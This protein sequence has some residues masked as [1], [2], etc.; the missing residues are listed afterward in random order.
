MDSYF[1]LVVK[2]LT[3]EELD[4]FSSECFDFG[5]A[6]VEE[7]LQF[8]QDSLEYE[9]KTV[10][11]DSHSVKVYFTEKPDEAKLAR[12]QNQYPDSQFLLSE[13]QNKDWMAEWK[14]SYKPFKLI[15]TFWVVPSWCEIPR[16][17]E[18]PIRIDPGMAF[19]T[20]THGT[21]QI[22]ARIIFEKLQSEKADSLI[23]V[24]TGT[25]ILAMLG[26]RLGVDKIVGTDI[27]PQACSVAEENF[28]LNGIKNVKLTSNDI[29]LISEKFDLV[30]ANIVDGVLIRLKDHLLR[31]LNANG[32]LIVSGILKE[33]KEIFEN[34]FIKAESLRVIKMYE[35]DEWLGYE[36]KAHPTNSYELKRK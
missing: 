17:C 28:E 27:D 35:K 33:R 36:L 24:G 26:R 9:P 1:C 21:T 34:D 20:G 25:G 6:G 4:L 32:S 7:E 10:D 18:K 19:G 13:E 31:M 2:N 16:E 30:V 29:S 8:T 3:T 14:K 5:A 12:L 23:D 22:C 11:V 15:D